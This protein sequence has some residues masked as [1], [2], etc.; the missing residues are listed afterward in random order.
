MELGIFEVRTLD[1]VRFAATAR[2]QFMALLLAGFAGVALTVAVVGVY[3]V[4][5]EWLKQRRREIGIRMAA[6]AFKAQM[7][8]W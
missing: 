5:A 7:S 8:E 4:I 1:E 6:G 3:T 2:E